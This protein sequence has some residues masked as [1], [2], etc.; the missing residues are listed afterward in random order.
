MD[1]LPQASFKSDE[2][3]FHTVKTWFGQITLPAGLR[4]NM[5]MEYTAPGQSSLQLILF[6]ISLEKSYNRVD[7]NPTANLRR[8]PA[9][10]RISSRNQWLLRMV[11]TS[12]NILVSVVMQKE[13]D[14][15][16]WNINCLI[17]WKVPL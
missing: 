8:Y 5:N 17:N 15:L 6:I 13:R 1:Y 16:K 14:F 4:A 2:F 12:Q 9:L 3:D 11:K 10:V 7:H